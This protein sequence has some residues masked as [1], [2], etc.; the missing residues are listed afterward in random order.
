MRKARQS[1]TARE[2]FPITLHGKEGPK[3]ERCLRQMFCIGGPCY[4]PFGLCTYSFGNPRLR[5][6]D[7]LGGPSCKAGRSCISMEESHSKGFLKYVEGYLDTMLFFPLISHAK[8]SMQALSAGHG[9][10]SG[11]FLVKQLFLVKVL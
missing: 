7:R 1:C 11:F 4:S 8:G 6:S 10:V 9:T 2:S 5:S 3:A